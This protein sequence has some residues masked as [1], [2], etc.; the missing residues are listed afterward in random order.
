MT[1]TA[2]APTRAPAPQ[3]RF[4]ERL[5]RYRSSDGARSVAIAVGIALTAIA[6]F[7]SLSVGT[8][9][10]TPPIAW[11]AILANLGLGIP[12]DLDTQR[13][14]LQVWE[15]RVP[16]VLLSVIGGGALAVAGVLFQGLL[17]NPLVS[18]YTLGI[19]PAAAFGASIAILFLG[20]VNFGIS[21]SIWTIIGALVFAIGASVL[22]LSLARFKRGDP[23][24][25]ILLGIAITQFFTAATG[26]LQYLAS[27]EVLALIVQWTWGSVN[28]ALWYQVAVLGAVFVVAYP[29]IQRRSGD[30]NAIAFAGDDAAKSL[31]VAVERVRLGLIAAAVVITAV[32][33]SFTGIIGFVGLVAPHIA[34]LV[35]GSNHRFLLPFAIVTGALLLVVADAVGRTVINPAVVPVGI[36]DALVGAPIFLYLILAKKRSS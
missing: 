12:T 36:V 4:A 20:P 13:L 2:P 19:A 25:L 1:A 28:G 9:T 29:L 30:L 6:A 15:L 14:Y 11:D 31:G 5:N 26:G 22:V 27:D 21:A 17:R 3:R 34:R 35:I 8:G 16:R 10:I 18:P 24:T 23:A 32:T 7:G 33:I